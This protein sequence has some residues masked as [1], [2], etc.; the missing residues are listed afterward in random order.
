SLGVDPLSCKEKICTFDCLYCQLGK[1]EVFQDKRKEFVPTEKIMEEIKSL[2]ILE[3]DYI[4]LSGRGEPTLARNLGEIIK[5]IKKIR[6]ENIAIITNSSL[7]DKKDVQEDLMLTDLVM[8][9]LDASSEDLFLAINKPM[10]TI[11]FDKILKGIKDFR[12]LYKGKLALQIMFIEENKLYA[13]EIAEIVKAIN[14][15][16]TQLNSPLRPCEVSPLSKEELD[17]IRDYFEGMDVV[18]VYESKRKAVKPVSKTCT[19]KRRGKV[20][21]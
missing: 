19:L 16:Q 2:P 9:K 13:G 7:I 4:T 12:S 20:D 3:M 6:K 1:T 11:K 8:V 17:N 18:S 15:D 14:P 21:T 10:Q 5:E